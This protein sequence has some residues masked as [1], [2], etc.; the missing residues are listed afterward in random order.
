MKK[1]LTFGLTALC[2]VLINAQS[3]ENPNIIIILAD[4][5][6]WGDVGYHGSEILTPNI[7]RLA[8]EG[9]ILNRYYTATICS[10]TRAGLLTGRYPDR[11]GI[12]STGIT[13][14]RDYGL[15]TT[16]VTL[17]DILGEAGYPHRAIIGKW[18]LGH[19]RPAWHPLNRGFTH[20]YGHLNGAIDFFT[21]EREGERDWHF[22]YSPSPD[23][24]YATELISKR[25]VECIKEYHR[26]GPFFIFVSYNAPHTPLQ[27]PLEDL[28]MYGY[29]ESQPQF[30]NALP[31]G[32][33][34]LGRGN[35]P[36]QTYSAMVTNMDRGI[37]HILETL[38]QLGIED[39]TLV[40][41]HSD[42]GAGPGGS[43]GPLRGRKYREWEG[44]VRAPAIIKWPAGFAGRWVSDQVMGFVDVVPTIRDI[45]G[46]KDEPN[47]PLDG[48][49]VLQP[50]KHPNKQFD[51]NLYLGYGTIINQHWK[52]IKA[53]SGAPH[54]DLEED[55]L[56]HISTDPY[57]NENVSGK[58][59]NIYL[60]L[61]EIVSEFDA[62]EVDSPVLPWGEGQEG[63]V[64]PKD[65]N[66]FQISD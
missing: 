16:E 17:P 10:P 45:I 33:G 32:E 29:D 44:G 56:F 5:L 50:L 39:N 4:D 55:M 23:Q 62:I 19:L 35:N 40:L 46:I 52:L 31:G 25:A 2:P 38:S 21:L 41:F 26:E 34:Y 13:P 8:S 64:A 63:F 22:D 24:G 11:V 57:E 53:E 14:W 59:Q 48:V 65:W 3:S 49:S 1:F 58:Y 28:L 12:R 61:S 27:A 36:R 51:R 30:G 7:D 9:I 37:G 66:I 47:L 6:G 15:D 20:F 18:H 43:S 60:K 54:M 42:N